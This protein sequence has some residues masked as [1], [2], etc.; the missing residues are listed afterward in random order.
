MKKTF[1]AVAAIT[2]SSYA[3][4]QDSTQ[5]K[6]LDEAIVTANKIIQK[7]KTTG[8]VISVI[9]KDQ[10]EKS[11]GRTVTQLLNEQAGLTINGA[12]NNLGTN[13]TV[14]MRG[15][16]SGR[17]LILVDGIPVYDPSFIQGEFD[18][19]F[20]SLNDVERIE[21]SRGA[22]STVYGSDAVAGVINIITVKK[23]IKK[24]VNA[25]VT[26]AAGSF[27]TWRANAQVYGKADKLTYTARYA[28]LKSNG[29]SIARDTAGNKGFD[30]DGYDGYATNASVQYQLTPAF[31]IKSYIQYSNYNN[32]I[33]AR[34]FVDEKDNTVKNKNLLTG[35][36]LRYQKNNVTVVGNYQYG[37]VYR[38]Y[39]NDSLDIA[40]F[41]KFSTDNY[42]GKNQFLEVFSNIALGNGF[43]LLQGADYRYSSMNNQSFSISSF[44]PFESGFPDTVHSQASLYGSVFYHSPNERLNLELGGR[45]NVHSRYGTNSTFTFNPSFN[46][47]KNFRLFGSIAT[48][49]KAP[50]LYQ[51]YSSYGN[52]D[53]K[54][55]KSTNY[56]VGVQQEHEW[57]RN[58]VV[59]FHRIIKDGL[60]F[61]NN[62]FQYFNF[63]KQTVWGIELESAIEPVKGFIVSLNYTYLHPEEESQ[64][65]ETF[66]DT[67]YTYLLKRPDHSINI[68]LG[69]QVMPALYVR[70]SGKYVNDRYDVGGYMVPDQ[71]LEKYFILGAYAEFKFFERFKAF[72]DVQN[73]TDKKFFDVWGFNS[74]PIAVNAGVTIQLND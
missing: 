73:L 10:I 72:A 16:P 24:P 65:R 46:I 35:A 28:Y 45:M 31:S 61:N 51:L 34:A 13:Q 3:N 52:P 64:S 67:T 54:P 26:L 47:S 74:T 6:Q 40:G 20:I 39:R 4:A 66:N 49:F 1:F 55:E 59:Y 14:Y 30:N 68:N 50:T 71:K 44:G 58:R 41:A 5:I 27:D 43:S 11:S 18:L 62:S 8:K 22:Q 15:A 53:L 37:D 7:Q 57:I 17:T 63:N 33:D 23:D 21:I 25:K 19:N 32:D 36:S 42:Y 12:N 60:D 29:F 48:A 70:V 9:G 69:Y 2:I 38:N 56:E